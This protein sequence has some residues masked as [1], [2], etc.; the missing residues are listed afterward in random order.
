MIYLDTTAVA[1]LIAAQPETEPLRDYLSRHCDV[2]WFTC[3]LTRVELAHDLPDAGEAIHTATT[4]LD[5]VNVSDRLLDAAIRVRATATVVDA[6]HIAAA[7]TAATLTAF[8][9]YDP[10]R[11]A[12]A[13]AAGLPVAHPGSTEVP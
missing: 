10:D 11:A 7:Q 3:A 13:R 1:K 6:L 5:T 2:R 8:I 9:T 4:A 12:A